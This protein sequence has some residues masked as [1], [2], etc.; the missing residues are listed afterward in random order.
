LEEPNQEVEKIESAIYTALECVRLGTEIHIN[1]LTLYNSTELARNSNKLNYRYSSIKPE[2]LFDT[3]KIVQDNVFAQ[4]LPELFPI[5]STYCDVRDWEIFTAKAYV[6]LPLIKGLTKTL[7][8]F[9]VTEKKSVWQVLEFVDDYFVEWLRKLDRSERH[10]QVVF[11]FAKHFALQNLSSQTKKFFYSELANIFLGNRKKPRFVNVLFKGD[12]FQAELAW[13]LNL[14]VFEGL[15]ADKISR[16]FENRDVLSGNVFQIDQTSQKAAFIS[17]SR[18]IKI[19]S[20]P[21][22]LWQIL[23]KFEMA[24]RSQEIIKISQKE[25][26]LLEENSWISM[27]KTQQTQVSV[28]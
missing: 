26:D 10:E 6:V 1:T 20:V 8:E 25:I 17:K 16:P 18:R 22:K 3:P 27:P 23:S 28:R 21:F 19:Y 9:V 24:S 4:A 12:I 14:Q 5:H 13:F 11:E 15:S 7:Y 2:L